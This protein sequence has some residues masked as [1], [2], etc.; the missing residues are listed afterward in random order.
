MARLLASGSV[1]GLITAA[2]T[3]A[4][5]SCSPIA[6]AQGDDFDDDTN[7]IEEIVVTGSR[8]KRRNLISSSPVTQ[9]NADEF[10][11]QGIT[12]IED[13]INDL[14]MVIA[15]QNSATN[16]GSDGTATINLR[17]LEATRT[18]TLLNGRRLPGG[19]P[20]NSAV[21]VNQIPGMMIERVEVLTGGASATYG[22]DAI[23]GVVNFITVDD[24]QG[25]QFDYQFSLYQHRNDS[26]SAQ[27]VTDAGYDLPPSNVN[28][29]E[30]HNFSMML[31][32]EGPGGRSNLTTYA[33]YRKINEVVQADRDHS[34]CQLNGGLSDF[35][36]EEF[37]FKGFFCGGSSTIPVGRFTDFGLLRNPDCVLIPAPT[38]EDPNAMT[39]NRIP[40]IDYASGAPTGALD[41]DGNVIMMNEPVLPWFGNTSGNGT[42][43]WPGRYDLLVDPGTH[44]FV[45]RSG[46][47]DAWYNFSPTNY[48]M[49][50]DERITLG[51]IGH[52][53]IND[54]AELYLELNFM[55]DQTVAQLA[56]SGS[57][58]W[59]DSISCGNPLLSQQQIDLICTPYN[60][61]AADN[62]TVFIGKRNVE[63][64]PRT[65]NVRH[66][67]Y[68]G[69]LGIRGDIGD[70]WSY[71]AFLNYGQVAS[72]E[73]F[74]EDLSITNMLRALDV[75]IDP[76]TGQPAC[77]SVVNGSD[78]LCVP[79][80]LFES[81]AV[82]QAAVD[83]ITLPIF[84]TGSTEQHQISAYASGDLGDYG[85]KLPSA[86]DGVKVVFGLEYRK[87][88]LDY[89]P[90]TTA[91]QGGAAGQGDAVSPVSGSY[92]V[93]EFFAEASIPLLQ[94][95]TAAELVSL[96]LAYRYSDYSTDKQT[97]TYK[98]A[99]AWM[100]VPSFRLRASF[101]HAV[102][103][104]NIHELFEP[105][106]NGGGDG[107]DTCS[108]DN[109]VST[110]EQCRLTGVTAA[111][112]GGISESDEF[113]FMQTKFG[114]NPQ[115]DPEKSDTISF[116]F[117]LNPDSLPAL[118][119]SVDY[120]EIDITDAIA[121]SDSGFIFEQCI[122][123][124]AAKFCDAIHRDSTTGLLWL[125]EGHVFAPNTN[126]GFIKTAGVDVIADYG[127][128]IGRFGD[129]NFNLVGT[130]L[131]TWDWQELPGEATFDCV[132]FF[133]GGPCYMPRPEWV[134]NFRTTWLTPWDASVT[135]LWR[136][137][138]GTKD[139]SGF[140]N[141]IDSYNY[142]DL[143]GV[144]DVSEGIT[145]RVGISNIMDEDPPL[146]VSG[147]GN[148]IP[149]AY[150]A[151]GRY[152]FTGFSVNF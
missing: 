102:R 129:L 94:G 88:L 30:A 50:P 52:Y 149:S 46:H 152:W 22:S 95:K 26:P 59:P 78:P 139:G 127:L 141:D 130:Y 57:F 116:G 60:L 73:I 12:R 125:G 36:E 101:Q 29:G 6:H 121:P 119:V 68:R 97:D 137:I 72:A 124:G 138:D 132:G 32:I 61:T 113:D 62:Q 150:D 146:T 100:I 11:F 84:F 135:L 79:W 145:V 112:Y 85:I 126:I 35:A 71:D 49:R 21:D 64:G 48:F 19:S 41:D 81:G 77:A 80:N 143:A 42:M 144:W 31:G 69:V 74:D 90:D 99:G 103:V 2:T 122:E 111:Q 91:Q 8:I 75:V 66:T 5:L 86:D 82:T 16:N 7:A 28:D 96:D 20:T 136:H 1:L 93:S 58:W 10:L 70:T 39:C 37:G 23:A 27:Y 92:S 34:A 40:Q 4:A 9:V 98:F 44:T 63:G 56:P 76:A 140:G 117:I 33:T 25:V 67:S 18:L 133:D 120:F 142:I 15:D 128:D 108:G 54:S 118:T 147:S 53:S 123:T 107:I 115:L 65:S 109:P 45:D 51:A 110:L 3:L 148:T 55:D 43:P 17:G 83:Y 87:E 151:L 105:I 24:F 131:D 38:P 14:P 47:P 104:G 106:T 114:G 134:S 89:L 13:L